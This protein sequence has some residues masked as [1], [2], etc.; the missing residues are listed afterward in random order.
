MAVISSNVPMQSSDAV[1]RT[2]SRSWQIPSKMPPG[3]IAELRHKQDDLALSDNSGTYIYL[4]PDEIVVSLPPSSVARMNP[5]LVIASKAK[6]RRR[7]AAFFSE[8]HS[9]RL[10]R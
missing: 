10:W 3:H 5:I 4:P 9:P 6:P 2:S 7:V 1:I 8:N